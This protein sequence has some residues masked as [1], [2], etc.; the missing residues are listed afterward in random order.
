MEVVLFLAVAGFL[1]WLFLRPQPER[2]AAAAQSWASFHGYATANGLQMLY[3]E[4]VYQRAARGSKAHVSIYGDPSGNKRDAWFWW[5]QVQKGSVVAVRPTVGWGPHTRRDDV[6]YIGTEVSRQSG[7]YGG[8][9]ARTLTNA[10]RHNN[11]R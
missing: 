9:D 6:L 1:A 2:D 8:I 7:V 10:R 5:T 4:H 3:V 11:R